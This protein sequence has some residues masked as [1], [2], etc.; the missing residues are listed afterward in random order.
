M[1]IHRAAG[2]QL[3]SHSRSN[4]A[5]MQWRQL[6]QSSIELS[7]NVKLLQL[8]SNDI[9]GLVTVLPSRGSYVVITVYIDET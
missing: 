5:D 1:N 8:A 9:R 6:P 7:K 3:L 2:E 4:T